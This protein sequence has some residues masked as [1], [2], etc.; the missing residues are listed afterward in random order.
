MNLVNITINLPEIF[1]QKID[2]LVVA[3]LFHSRS[4]ALR[5][6]IKEFLTREI[7]FGAGLATP[8]FEEDSQWSGS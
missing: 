3:K 8:L 5:L 7:A 4:E 6:A 2:D 1:L